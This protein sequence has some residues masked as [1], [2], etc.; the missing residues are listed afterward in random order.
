MQKLVLVPIGPESSEAGNVVVFKSPFTIGRAATNDLPLPRRNVSGKH[1][2]LEFDTTTLSWFV[3]DEG[4][5][6]GTFVAGRRIEGRQVLPIGSAI[7]FAGCL[8][9]VASEIDVN[10]DDSTHLASQT[11]FTGTMD[12]LDVIDRQLTYPHFQPIFDLT[13]RRAVA[14]EALGRATTPEGN[15]NPGRM[16]YLA[17]QTGL[18]GSLSLCFRQSATHCVECGHCWKNDPAPLIFINIHPAEI[19][20]ESMEESLSTLAAAA[21]QANYTIVIEAPESWVSR[22]EEMKVLVQQIRQAGMKVAYDDFGAGQSRLHDLI[23]V[24]P[25]F[26]KF[27]RGLIADITDQPVKRKLVEAVIEACREL[28]VITLAEGIETP[29]ELEAC[30]SMGI[31]LAQGFLLGRPMPAYT[32]FDAQTNALPSTCQYV[33]LELVSTD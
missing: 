13:T 10:F 31:D 12:V 4:S 29:K 28:D 9:R 27:D 26:L 11:A 17:E 30:E 15:L 19:V 32:L 8:F 14:W 24:P 5:T 20:A 33:K 18:Q 2:R 3:I 21:R 6:N 22:T 25:D 23:T 16:F 1:A 7:T